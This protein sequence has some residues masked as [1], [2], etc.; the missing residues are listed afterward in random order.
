MNKIIKSPQKKWRKSQFNAC[1][2]L[3]KKQ[4]LWIK[5][6]KITKTNAG[7]LDIIINFYKKYGDETLRKMSK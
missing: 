3:R 7:M 1:I 5:K 2:K 6:N 4:L